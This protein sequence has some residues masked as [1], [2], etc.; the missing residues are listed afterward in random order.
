MNV[1]RIGLFLL[2]I[3]V[4]AVLVFAQTPTTTSKTSDGIIVTLTYERNSSG[5]TYYITIENTTNALLNVEVVYAISSGG[6]SVVG[7]KNY[8]LKPKE[9]NGPFV[10]AQYN[11]NNTVSLR[12]IIVTR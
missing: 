11:N 6:R 5:R 1:K 2:L 3:V 4:T 10:F 9:T 8:A 12:E 7:R